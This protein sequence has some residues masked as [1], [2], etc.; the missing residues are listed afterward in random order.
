MPRRTGRAS[1]I[2]II[3][4]KW[5]GRK[6]NV[7]NAPG[8][9]PTPDRARETLFAWLGQDIEEARCLDLFAGAGAL[10]LEA[11]SRGARHCTFVEL[12]SPVVAS[13]RAQ[14]DALGASNQAT[15][16]RADARSWLKINA[17]ANIAQPFDIAF[18]DPPFASSLLDAVLPFVVSSLS[19]RA[20]LVLERP[21]H[22]LDRPP[23]LALPATEEATNLQSWHTER[24]L[25]LGESTIE[26]WRRDR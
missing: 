22:R 20:V 11:L 13:L 18:L 14:L 24:S 12:R 6:L 23:S 26:L 4:G 2:R 17:A 8:L 3:G 16:V 19:P 9:R 5:R 25:A 10:G 1:G 15:L 21:S 7:P